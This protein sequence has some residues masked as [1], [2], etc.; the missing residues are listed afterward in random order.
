[1]GQY[2][3]RHH[4]GDP[5]ASDPFVMVPPAKQREAL[6]FLVENIFSD[7]AFTFSP[8]LLNKL[9]AGRWGHWDSDFF[10]KKQR[11]LQLSA[12]PTDRHLFF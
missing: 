10:P 8:E 5:G 12:E 3:H 6:S 4:K 9:A 7:Q 2:V 1:G 11:P